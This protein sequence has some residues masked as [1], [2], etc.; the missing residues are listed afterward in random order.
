MAGME[1]GRHCARV[2]LNVLCMEYELNVYPVSSLSDD[3]WFYS[4]PLCCSMFM[5]VGVWRQR[6][7]AG[8]E[9]CCLELCS[10]HG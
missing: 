5:S 6:V 4:L 7:R 1:R 2:H 3:S 9:S 10:E 8:P